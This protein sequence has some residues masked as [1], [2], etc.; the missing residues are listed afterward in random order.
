MPWGHLAKAVIAILCLVCLCLAPS[1]RAQEP[2]KAHL[3]Q[4]AYL[5]WEQGYILHSFGEYESAAERFRQSIEAYPT[6]E[7][8]TFLGWSLS[9][10]GKTEEAITQCKKAIE[11]DP[12]YGNPYNDIGVYL[13]DLGRL[14]EA[15]PWLKKAMQAKRYCCAHYPHYNL[16]RVLLMKGRVEA[17]VR[18]FE[19][20]LSHDPDYRPARKAL[21]IVK[22]REGEAL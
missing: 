2:E 10:L 8:H 19:R 15:I 11:L 4:Q 17:A 20:A 7:G 16:G 14:D 6:A 9:H 3:L 22:E 21:E 5:L 1:L 13:I 18:A 12:D